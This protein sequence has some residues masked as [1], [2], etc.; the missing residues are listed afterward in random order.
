M[1]IVL[2]YLVLIINIYLG[3][4]EF[5]HEISSYPNWM[6]SNM[7]EATT[8]VEDLTHQNI[9]LKALKDH[10]KSRL[11]YSRWSI[12]LSIPL[13]LICLKIPKETNDNQSKSN[14]S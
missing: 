1:K 11:H 14:K 8:E 2:I 4:S 5:G 12:I 3:F 6:P 13:L 9:K 7:T 10:Y